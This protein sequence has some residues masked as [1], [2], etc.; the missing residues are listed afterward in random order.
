MSARPGVLVTRPA[1]DAGPLAARLEALG[2]EPVLEPMLTIRLIDGPV[3]ML[4]DVQA[5]VF[6]S[7]NGVRAY[8]GRT[9][10]RDRPVYAVGGATAAAAA[11]IGF[12]RVRSAGGDVY[13]L[14]RLIAAEAVPQQGLL[15]HVAG[16][17]VAG[18]LAG[19]LAGQGFRVRKE[20]LYDAVPVDRIGAGAR[21]ALTA[22]GLRA[23]LF[24]SPRT[25]RSFVRLLAEDALPDHM[26][27]V[28]ALCL[29]P[30]VATAARADD[31]SPPIPWR[32][33]RVAP[34]PDQESLLGLLPA[35]GQ[36]T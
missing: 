19:L 27:T 30:A 17:A 35:C 26:R 11:A 21:A 20:A 14:A 24:F 33:V 10:R 5:L 13:A 28:D 3:P 7:A 32:S 31:G 16:T 6:T 34:H 2:Y 9:D 18:D 29:S 8:A 12:A 23:V 25:A 22:G 4:D 15:L 36:G 1:E